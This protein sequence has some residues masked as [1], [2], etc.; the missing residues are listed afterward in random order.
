MEDAA[1]TVVGKI[2][3]YYL[4]LLES[5][6]D[7]SI[8]QTFLNMSVHELEKLAKSF[9]TEL[10]QKQA[11]SEIV[12]EYSM[13]AAS[14]EAFNNIVR[15]LGNATIKDA[16]TIYKNETDLSNRF[17]NYLIKYYTD[18]IHQ[19]DI[20]D[21]MLSILQFNRDVVNYLG[22][23]AINNVFGL[24]I[25]GEN[26]NNPNYVYKIF[27]TFLKETIGKI[28]DTSS[29]YMTKYLESM[30]NIFQ[31]NKPNNDKITYT[32][33]L[34]DIATHYLNLKD[35]STRNAYI[36]EHFFVYA[37]N[38]ADPS[39]IGTPLTTD[40][41]NTI[42]D[43]QKYFNLAD[44]L[45]RSV[46][47]LSLNEKFEV[48]YNQ[49]CN[50]Q[51]DTEN[52]NDSTFNMIIPNT[53]ES[54]RFSL[55]FI[56]MSTLD[57]AYN[58][59]TD[60]TNDVLKDIKK[61]NPNAVNAIIDIH[62]KSQKIDILKNDMFL[63]EFIWIFIINFIQNG[64]FNSIF[65]T[66]KTTNTLGEFKSII[67]AAYPQAQYIRYIDTDNE[68]ITGP[69][70]N[71]MKKLKDQFTFAP[72]K[73][74][75][76]LAIVEKADPQKILMTD[77]D[78][79]VQEKD[80]HT[81]AFDIVL[82]TRNDADNIIF[83]YDI[84][85]CSYER[86]TRNVIDIANPNNT[87]IKLM[88][89]N[90]ISKM[91]VD[92][93]AKQHPAID[94]SELNTFL[95]VEIPG[96]VNST[97]RPLQTND[98]A[99][100]ILN[101][102][103][104]DP[105]NTSK[106]YPLFEY[107]MLNN[108]NPK[109]PAPISG[110][111]TPHGYS[112]ITDFDRLIYD[113]YDALRLFTN[114]QATTELKQQYQE[115][116]DVM[117][118]YLIDISSNANP[119]FVNMQSNMA[120]YIATFILK[121]MIFVI[122]GITRDNKAKNL[123]SDFEVSMVDDRE[124]LVFVDT[125][126][127]IDQ[128]TYEEF[129]GT[130]G[131][132]GEPVKNGIAKVFDDDEIASPLFG[133]NPP[134]QSFFKKCLTT[135]RD[136]IADSPNSYYFATCF[137]YKEFNIFLRSTLLSELQEYIFV[138]MFKDRDV[139]ATFPRI[140][141]SENSFADNINTA[142]K[143][144]TDNNPVTSLGDNLIYPYLYANAYH[145]RISNQSDIIAYYYGDNII[146]EGYG[147]KSYQIQEIYLFLDLYTKIRNIYYKVWL[148]KSFITED[149]YPAY[150]KFMI[151]AFTIEKFLDEKIENIHNL[152]FFDETDVK[153]FLISYGLKEL[154]EKEQFVG[155]FD[156]QFNIVK[157]FNELVRN[158]GSRR[159]VS[160]LNDILDSEAYDIEVKK[161][162]LLRTFEKDQLTSGEYRFLELNYDSSNMLLDIMQ[163]IES[164]VRYELFV[165]DDPYWKSDVV[166]QKD[167]E[168]IELNTEVSKY[169]GL[170]IRNNIATSY[171][172]TRYILSIMSILDESLQ[173]IPEVAQNRYEKTPG[174]TYLE[175]NAVSAY[176]LLD[177]FMFQ[178]DTEDDSMEI[179]ISLRET[180]SNIRF[181]FT[182]YKK[183][184]DL[185][186]GSVDRKDGDYDNFHLGYPF[187]LSLTKRYNIL[188][189]GTNADY[190]VYN[191]E[192]SIPLQRSENYRQYITIGNNITEELFQK[193]FNIRSDYN[194]FELRRSNTT[195][196]LYYNNK[197]VKGTVFNLEAPN[198]LSNPD[199]FTFTES[200]GLTAHGNVGRKYYFSASTTKY[201]ILDDYSWS[202]CFVANINDNTLMRKASVKAINLF[203]GVD[204]LKVQSIPMADDAAYTGAD[205]ENSKVFKYLNEKFFGYTGKTDGGSLYDPLDVR[206]PE[207]PEIKLNIITNDADKKNFVKQFFLHKIKYYINNADGTN[208]RYMGSVQCKANDDDP[209]SFNASY[210]QLGNVTSKGH[211]FKTVDA[212]MDDTLF[213]ALGASVSS[214]NTLINERENFSQISSKETFRTALE[215]LNPL[216]ADR[217]DLWFEY[218]TMIPKAEAE[219]EVKP[220]INNIEGS[221]N[222]EYVFAN[223]INT[224]LEFPLLYH[225]GMFSQSKYDP[226]VL[227]NKASKDLADAIA[228]DFY[229]VEQD[230]MEML[231]VQ[232]SNNELAE[233][234][235]SGVDDVLD[236]VVS[237]PYPDINGS[238]EVNRIT[239]NGINPTFLSDLRGNRET[240]AT[241]A[242]EGISNKLITL[243]NTFRGI[244]SSQEYAA[245]NVTM[246]EN[247]SRLKDYVSDAVSFFISYTTRLYR[248][249]ISRV[250]DTKDE[251][252][253]LVEDLK[254][255][256][257]Q[258]FTDAYNI[259][260]ALEVAI[261]DDTTLNE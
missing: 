214:F 183:V 46:S 236:L 49:I 29:E 189:K 79:T 200:Y 209:D 206:D 6:A 160:I 244:F 17:S 98:D 245:I 159:I 70:I 132:P 110:E 242:L 14:M 24:D 241:K 170:T 119:V 30:Q 193:G 26:A 260:E 187:A 237:K 259:G 151:S 202:D 36:Q 71:I 5:M 176:N 207:N 196:Q 213:K 122:P 82:R 217:E 150:E 240:R 116:L 153:N 95:M 204:R 32:E 3:I 171:I 212:N 31:I 56:K 120:I 243:I 35:N 88:S 118:Q 113:L 190:D 48:C 80:F 1:E 96:I 13:S 182:M 114:N 65:D 231:R 22:K 258:M 66:T 27:Q 137:L 255:Y 169:I 129:M 43:S 121:E 208:T 126:V 85:L 250:Y 221:L 163:N 247:E 185:V 75:F 124:H 177:N 68:N 261:S 252:L 233:F 229:M 9:K 162:L 47:S 188:N 69:N 92:E 55:G 234:L 220:Q 161:Y 37:K 83:S 179:N 195:M 53:D 84:P 184:N 15:F 39:K 10:I 152:D 173:N 219:I 73:S 223:L 178:L 81:G 86:T 45:L 205:I 201:K 20:V 125:N 257:R 134:V 16:T 111:Y 115:R 93:F 228:E 156:M 140:T 144:Y 109:Y 44:L 168:N 175:C 127:L 91:F 135:S 77:I 139:A 198:S 167:L 28:Q 194:N 67:Q 155:Q 133:A 215:G 157:N 62:N 226:L 107:L 128:S 158:K 100:L 105:K 191:A 112:V 238:S 74:N 232:T 256:G 40:D 130:T 230:P 34:D 108:T 97:S 149:E 203:Y 52:Y 164:A 146:S 103:V 216:L 12:E 51:G 117:L 11:N 211:L 94:I 50:T 4:Q 21:M 197:V 25:D 38:D 102:Y 33:V 147:R 23:D 106:F 235:T 101:E 246:A 254:V 89:I 224:A 58:N 180:I 138:R 8:K 199:H 60:T 90:M 143:T 2:T 210:A 136:A 18:G 64:S 57:T 63:R 142:Y 251:S 192:H 218:L 54:F 253:K 165:V 7:N 225:N 172:I 239:I 87:N 104:A 41:F 72:D 19:T 166:T 131:K 249:S 248:T 123:P 59:S 186:V 42:Q 99:C 141:N 76:Q 181:L 61:N 78:G 154:T 227:K 222:T 145:A 174:G 148:N